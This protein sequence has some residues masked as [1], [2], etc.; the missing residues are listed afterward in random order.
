MFP[1]S[2]NKN[3]NRNNLRHNTDISL[4]NLRFKN[5]LNENRNKLNKYKRL[6]H[7]L[8][9]NI[10]KDQAKQYKKNVEDNLGPGSYSPNN[11]YNMKKYNQMAKTININ[12]RIPSYI[13]MN[14]NS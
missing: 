4:N 9:F 1:I 7:N 8:R 2:L 3:S 12:E 10:I 6:L 14:D 13:D 11:F 5:K